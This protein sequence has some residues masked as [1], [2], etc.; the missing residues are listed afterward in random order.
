MHSG[1]PVNRWTAT[2]YGRAADE[3]PGFA[4]IAAQLKTALTAVSAV[5]YRSSA[6]ALLGR[7]ALRASRPSAVAPLGRRAPRPSRP[8]AVAPLG[9]SEVSC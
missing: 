7:R 8:S 4:A 6:N 3:P 2:E 9:P 1:G 5:Q